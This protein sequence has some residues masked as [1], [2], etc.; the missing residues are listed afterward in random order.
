[1]HALADGFQTKHRGRVAVCLHGWYDYFQQYAYDHRSEGPLYHWTAFPGTTKVPM[2][3][4][5]MHHRMQF[6]KEPRLPRLLYFSDGTNSDSGAPN[7]HRIRAEGPKRQKVSGLEGTGFGGK[8]VDDGP[9]RAGVQGL[10][11]RLSDS[12][13]RRYASDIDGFVWDETF[14]IKTEFV[15]QTGLP[16]HADRAMMSLVSELTQI[17]QQ[18]HQQQPGP[19]IPRLGFRPDELCF[20]GPRHVPRQCL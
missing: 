14:Y 7:F 20:G 9:E 10:V 2:S 19:G 1:M 12:A 18:R 11:S 13:A 4:E 3:L 16:A 15:P 17:V 5:D 6:A 8:P